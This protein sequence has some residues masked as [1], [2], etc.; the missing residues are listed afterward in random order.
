MSPPKFELTRLANT[1]GFVGGVTAD[2][3][4]NVYACNATRHSVLR[5]N[6]E[7]QEAVF[8]ERAPDGPLI[9]PN[10][11][12]FDKTGNY[13]VSDSGDYWKPNGRLIRG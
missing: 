12:S 5:V 4:N 3:N 11:G 9:M 1:K 10:Y 13:Y 7:G 8:C 6:Q 2:A